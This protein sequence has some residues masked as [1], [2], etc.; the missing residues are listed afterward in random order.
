MTLVVLLKLG[1]YVAGVNTVSDVHY[2]ACILDP[3]CS[4]LQ[5]LVVQSVVHIDAYTVI[6]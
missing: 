4:M 5:Q 2:N 6:F 3:A 1:K